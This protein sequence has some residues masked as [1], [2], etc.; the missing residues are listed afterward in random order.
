MA[1]GFTS[2]EEALA[3]METGEFRKRFAVAQADAIRMD[4][5]RRIAIALRHHGHPE[6]GTGFY[7]AAAF[8]ERRLGGS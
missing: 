2:R 4:E 1:E 7:E 3:Y 8:I 6:G 5:R